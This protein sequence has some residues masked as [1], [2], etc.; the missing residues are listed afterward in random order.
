MPAKFGF[1]RNQP[2]AAIHEPVMSVESGV[3][4]G[5]ALERMRDGLSVAEVYDRIAPA[6]FRTARR[7]GVPEASL[8]DVVQ[9]VFLVVHRRLDSFDGSSSLKTWVI[10]ITLRV[11]QDH[12]RSTRRRIAHTIHLEDPDAFVAAGSSPERAA[13]DAEDLAF[14]HRFLE[15]LD[16]DKRIAFVLAELEEMTGAEIATMTGV[17]VNTIHTRLRAARAAFATALS[18]RETPRR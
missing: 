14:L 16:A 15:R 18:T 7:L 3:G 11:I 4:K 1:E 2:R 10:G 5:Q 8:D 12:R 6:V 13:G 17:N 9:D